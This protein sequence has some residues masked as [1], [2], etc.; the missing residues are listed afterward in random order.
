MEPRRTSSYD[1]HHV[2]RPPVVHNG[3]VQL[4]EELEAEHRLI[5]AAVGALRTYVRARAGG[6]A[7]ASDAPRFLRF[8]RLYAAQFHHAREEDTLFRALLDRAN[9]PEAGPI[10]TLRDDHRRTGALLDRIEAII[11]RDRLDPEAAR[12]LEQLAV[13]YSQALW[14]HIDAE[15][16][17]LFPES[18][19][20]LRRSGVL[21]L[22]SRD[23]T[24]DERHARDDG[25]AL[26][27]LYPPLDDRTII[28]GDGCVC[29]PALVEGCPGLE[30]AWWSDSE[31]E[32]LSDHLGEG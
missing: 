13:E 24:P 3:G 5:D 15:N 25:E 8:F 19:A 28:R 27:R 11:G 4:I 14:H 10:A 32:E 18:E 23:M 9:L 30:F 29:C 21:E 31:W 22:P 26:V 1:A 7:P 12:R 6:T 2:P 17:V 20:R 16:S